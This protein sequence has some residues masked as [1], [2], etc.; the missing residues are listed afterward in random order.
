MLITKI[1]FTDSGLRQ[2]G[3][4]QRYIRFHKSPQNQIEES[5]VPA[6]S[7]LCQQKNK[8]PGT[9]SSNNRN[10]P[11]PW[12][13]QPALYIGCCQCELPFWQVGSG[14][15]STTGQARSYSIFNEVHT[16]HLF[17]IY[18]PPTAPSS[19]KLT[20]TLA[21]HQIQTSIKKYLNNI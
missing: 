20:F 8:P 2:Q 18:P 15:F 13:D 11:R 5:A 9:F 10:S 6:N 7:P 4:N 16:R 17:R 1:D 12:P 3:Q 19:L 14:E 21:I